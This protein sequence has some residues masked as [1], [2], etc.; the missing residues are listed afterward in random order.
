VTD[1]MLFKEI[2][3]EIGRSSGANDEK[4]DSLFP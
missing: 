2:A 1:D 3:L 4:I